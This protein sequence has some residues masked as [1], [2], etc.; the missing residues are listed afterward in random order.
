M[1][2]RGLPIRCQEDA[3]APEPDPVVPLELTRLRTHA[4]EAGPLAP[5]PFLTSLLPRAMIST[6]SGREAGPGLGALAVARHLL[7]AHLDVAVAGGG[8][9]VGLG[10]Q[11]LSVNYESGIPRLRARVGVFSYLRH[12]GR[13]RAGQLACDLSRRRRSWA[14]QSCQYLSPSI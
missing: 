1:E 9:D 7:V 11:A 6:H 8:L 3:P 4:G 13:F 12:S 10:A 14:K 2:H 5:T